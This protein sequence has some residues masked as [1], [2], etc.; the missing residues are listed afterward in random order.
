MR[1][2]ACPYC[3]VERDTKAGGGQRLRC[4]GCGRIFL[5]PPRLTGAGGEPSVVSAPAAEVRPAEVRRAEVRRAEAVTIRR[6]ARPRARKA[7][8]A[9]P[10]EP[11]DPVRAP[12][13]A[14]PIPAVVS[15]RRGGLGS[16]MYR[17]LRRG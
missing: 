3:G 11:P 6:A 14:P 12:Q 4:R 5:A 1:R 9:S 13:A 8:E 7:E 10:A 2:I 16:A 15:G 17:R